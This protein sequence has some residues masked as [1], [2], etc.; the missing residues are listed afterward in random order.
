MAIRADKKLSLR[1]DSELVERLQDYASRERVP[2]SYVM[3]HLVL[4]FL[5]GSSKDPDPAS[6]SP[7]AKAW[8]GVAGP[9]LVA[10]RQAEFSV[11]VCALFDGFRGQ[12]HDARESAKRTNFALK[13]KK[14][15]WAT[16]EVVADV[17][18]QAGRFRK[19]RRRGGKD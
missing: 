8:R 1:L 11:E 16:Y 7:I 5:S 9:D 6:P 2:V 18:R 12:G 19:D 17:L 10:K 4:R 14:H 3:R 15:P 13:A